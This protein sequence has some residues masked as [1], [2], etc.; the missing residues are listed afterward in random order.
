MKLRRLLVA[1]G[2]GLAAGPGF[3][4]SACPWADGEYRFSNYGV[5]GD[6]Q[7]NSDCTEVVW[8]HLTEPEVA[9]LEETSD[10]W[11]GKLSKVSVVL[12]RDGDHLNVTVYGGLSRRSKAERRN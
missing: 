4:Q 1:I 12:L 5:Y 11:S 2:V 9:S 10:G 6:F 8:D 7:V 3:A